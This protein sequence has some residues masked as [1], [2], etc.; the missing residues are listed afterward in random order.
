MSLTKDDLQAIA[1][2]FAPIEARMEAGFTEISERLGKVEGRLDSVEQR[3][4]RVEQRLDRVEQRLD[5]VEQ[6]LD[7]V[8]QRLDKLESD[9]AALKAGQ[10]SLKK[11]IKVLEQKVQDTYELALEA[12]GKSTENRAMIQEL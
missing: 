2:L 4:D 9:T 3:L 10:L 12:W 8:E 5:R 11:D 1:G 7:R 6:R